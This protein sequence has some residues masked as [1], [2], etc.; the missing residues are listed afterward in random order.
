V[1]TEN[2]L[3]SLKEAAKLTGYTADYIGQL[4]RAGKIP[5]KQVYCNIAWMTT[6]K[7]VAEYK[8][9]GQNDK[10]DIQEKI[11]I[12]QRKIALE[13]NIL[14]ML[15][16]SFRSAL[17]LLIILFLSFALI[18]IFLVYYFS[19]QEPPALPNNADGTE[20]QITF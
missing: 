18:N 16:F 2:D 12:A 1:A 14:K 10:N 20:K 4:I 7:A 5:G 15:F 19:H 13:F 8:S 11:K 6:A 9:K 3:I 17:P